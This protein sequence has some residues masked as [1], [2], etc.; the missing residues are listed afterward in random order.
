MYSFKVFV[1]LFVCAIVRFGKIFFASKNNFLNSFRLHLLVGIP[2]RHALLLF[3]PFRLSVCLSFLLPFLTFFFFFPSLS[4]FLSLFFSSLTFYVSRVAHMAQGLC[5][6]KRSRVFFMKTQRILYSLVA[7]NSS[8]R[9]RENENWKLAHQLFF[10]F[11]FFVRLQ[12]FF[13]TVFFCSLDYKFLLLL[14]QNLQNHSTSNRYKLQTA[15]HYIVIHYS[16]FHTLLKLCYFF[17]KVHS[18]K[19]FHFLSSCELDNMFLDISLLV[20]LHLSLGY[21]M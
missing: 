12:V 4:H 3:K 16:L 6:R 1:C 9:K 8:R 5:V 10:F 2:D 7:L 20:N 18:S 21:K 14:S 19:T 13:L 15:I 11:V 17:S